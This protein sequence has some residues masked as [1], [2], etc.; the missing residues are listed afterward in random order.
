MPAGGYTSELSATALAGKKI[1]YF[2]PQFLP[3]GNA[4]S[5]SFRTPDAETQTLYDTAIDLFEAEGATI[6]GGDIFGS[7]WT[8]KFYSAPNAPNS[9]RY[10]QWK[11]FQNLGPT[12]PFD[13]WETYKAELTAQGKTFVPSPFVTETTDMV[14]TRTTAAGM[15]WINWQTEFRTLF[16]ATLDTLGLD[17]LVWPVNGKAAPLLQT[18]LPGFG[19]Q[20]SARAGCDQHPGH[21]GRHRAGGRVCRRHAVRRDRDRPVL[22]RSEPARPGLRLR[23][24]RRRHFAGPRGADADS[25]AVEHD[26]GNAGR[27]IA[28]G[29]PAAN[30]EAADCL[31]GLS[32]ECSRLSVSAAAT[33]ARSETCRPIAWRSAS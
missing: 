17:A 29:A 26:A 15:A 18:G 7:T 2:D 6:F 22:G 4:G 19:Q 10:D 14:D 9:Q 27:R 32:T 3:L 16:T 20:R 24:W 11:Y 23:A 1:G 31:C 30:G 21:A 12:T 8:D 28:A 25:R 33:T 5:P 13:S